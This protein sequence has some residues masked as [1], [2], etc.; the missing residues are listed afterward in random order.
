MKQLN[1]QMH[2]KIHISICKDAHKQFVYRLP[3]KIRGAIQFFKCNYYF[4]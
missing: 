1:E 3:F 4:H 2:I